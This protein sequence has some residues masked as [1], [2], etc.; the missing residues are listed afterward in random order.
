MSP[1]HFTPGLLAVKFRRTRSGHEPRTRRPGQWRPV[2]S[3]WLC[4]LQALGAHDGAHRVRARL[5]ASAGQGG[6]S[7][8]A[9]RRVARE[10]LKTHSIKA[11]SSFLRR[12]VLDGSRPSQA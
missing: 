2:L 6:V 3:A 8:A 7:T 1:T 11:L 9:A 4:G 5:N 10:L 12:T